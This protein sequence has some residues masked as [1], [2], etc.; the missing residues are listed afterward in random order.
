M[1]VLNYSEEEKSF[2][3]LAD[4]NRLNILRVIKENSSHVP[5]ICA[6]DI[7]EKLNISQSTLSHHMKIL[8]EAKFI[9]SVKKGKWVYYSLNT[10]G[11]NTI[12]NTVL[13]LKPSAEEI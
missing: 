12:E 9:I 10:E 3:A 7:L 13:E 4:A 5:A 2:K 11:F 1:S 8:S 6:C